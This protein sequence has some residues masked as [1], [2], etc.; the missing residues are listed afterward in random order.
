M[1]DNEP[2]VKFVDLYDDDGRQYKRDEIDMLPCCQSCV[3][4]ASEGF[5]GVPCQLSWLDQMLTPE[6]ERE[7]FSCNAYENEG[8]QERVGFR[9]Q[10]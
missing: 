6:D 7:P 8:L 10:A 5:T 9:C 2:D 3:R 1:N 4:G